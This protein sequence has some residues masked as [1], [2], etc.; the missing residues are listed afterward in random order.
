MALLTALEDPGDEVRIFLFDVA[1]QLNGEVTDGLGEQRL[2]LM[3]AVV[4]VG[5]SPV[6]PGSPSL[7]ASRDKS[8]RSQGNQMLTR[9]ALGVTAIASAMSSTEASPRL[10]SATRVCRCAGDRSVKVTATRSTKEFYLATTYY[11]SFAR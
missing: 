9:A 3:G 7:L 10:F 6:V 2:A 1:E 4:E 5:R 8:S 11:V